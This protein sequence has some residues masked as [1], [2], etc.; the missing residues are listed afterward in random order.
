MNL[1]IGYA[2]VYVSDMERA[3]RFY[4]DA[5]GLR[6]EH[7]DDGFGYASFDAGPI[8]M[9]ILALQP[10]ADNFD[11]LVGGHTGIAFTVPE[12]DPVFEALKERGVVFPM[13]PA[14]QPWGGRLALL[15]DPDGNVFYLD[16]VPADHA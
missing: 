13:E 16:Q 6:L 3:V 10:G 9:G 14:D 2:N 7:R 4:R 5:L 15:A 8:R 12:I 1:Q 11:D